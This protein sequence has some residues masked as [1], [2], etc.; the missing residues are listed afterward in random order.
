MKKLLL[1]VVGAMVCVNVAAQESQSVSDLVSMDEISRDIEWLKSML[2][3][4]KPQDYYVPWKGKQKARGIYVYPVLDVSAA[5]LSQ[6]KQNTEPTG[7]S[8]NSSGCTGVGLE[9]G[10]TIIFVPG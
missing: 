5:I 2:D 10:G 9:F 7:A 3:K 8:N 6:K 4:Q 1:F